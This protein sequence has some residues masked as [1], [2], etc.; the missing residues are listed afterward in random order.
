MRGDW[1]RL[2]I[3]ELRSGI[4]VLQPACR[5]QVTTAPSCA[6]IGHIPQP[7][8]DSRAVMP[9][10]SGLLLPIFDEFADPAVV[11][12]LSVDGAENRLGSARRLT[13]RSDACRAMSQ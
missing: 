8:C 10:R 11:A 2:S 4:G 3:I 1:D 13:L 7:D 6:I 5:G 12:G 9:M